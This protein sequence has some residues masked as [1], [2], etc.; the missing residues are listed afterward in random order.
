[1]STSD[2]CKDGV[3]NSKSN[4]D[5]CEMVGKLKNMSTADTSTEDN[6]ISLCAYCGKEGANNVC[7]KCKKATYCNAVCKKVHK[8]KH[9]KD[10][11]E[12]IR[13]AAELHDIELFKQPPSPL[14]DCP[15]CYL[16][17]PTL[18][19][20]RR[21]QTC[22]GKVV[23]SGC[24]HAPVFDNQGNEVDNRKCPFCRTPP[25]TTD[26]EMIKREKKRADLDDPIALYNQGNWYFKGRN[27]C[28]QD[29]TKALERWHRAAELGHV[30]AYLNLGYF[31]EMG[32]GAENNEEKG[33]HY[34]ELAA[35]RGD[36]QARANLAIKEMKA[37][38]FDRAIKHHLIAVKGGD[39]N[40]LRKIKV[41][42]SNGHAT[43]EDYTKALQLY[44]A[45]LGEIKSDQ[46]DKAAAFDGDYRYY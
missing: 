13:V 36:A 43:K 40:S 28:T 7:N 38:N 44:Q 5:V 25:P 12:H 11:E 20:G 41:M 19:G 8:K 34:Y 6:Y 3:S 39:S 46:R 37:G 30:K 17:L 32:K 21:Y 18:E 24:I 29:D 42:Y 45:Y 22:C 35:M 31:Y 27:G 26:E 4:D 16:R 1:M 10:C 33:V 2:N 14:R 23:C 15:I 9:K